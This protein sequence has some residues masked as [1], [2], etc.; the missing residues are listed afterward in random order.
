MTK[1][2]WFLLLA[3]IPLITLTLVG[4]VLF[5]QIKKFVH[6]DIRWQ[7]YPT[8]QVTL[9]RI[10]MGQSKQSTQTIL[11][12]VG[13]ARLSF[14][15]FLLQDVDVYL[16]HP[17]AYAGQ[18][19]PSLPKPLH[20]QSVHIQNLRV[21][22]RNNAVMLVAKNLEGTTSTLF[23]DQLEIPNIDFDLLK[24]WLSAY[25]HI[26]IKQQI[27]VD[28]LRFTDFTFYDFSAKLAQHE[29]M[30]QM[31]EVK[32]QLFSGDLTGHSLLNLNPKIPTYQFDAKLKHANLAAVLSHS[33]K[34]NQI[35][36]LIDLDLH[37]TTAGH[38]SKE[39]QQNAHGETQIEITQCVYQGNEAWKALAHSLGSANDLS[40]TLDL[41]LDTPSLS[42]AKITPNTPSNH[43]TGALVIQ[44]GQ[45]AGVD[46]V[47]N[48]SFP[49]KRHGYI[50]LPHELI[51]LCFVL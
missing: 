15:G 42:V 7:F 12:T 9:N 51:D 29:G 21:Q 2:G 17:E 30:V 11:A 25:P 18:T 31:S 44:Q 1:K 8:L 36:G 4:F 34:D 28:Q 43:I 26:V 49:I 19:F 47:L 20:L 40:D 14:D 33:A 23:A 6:G 37:I 16:G 10:E 22:G 45:V 24:E 50:D 32:A 48:D 46:L 39:M 41:M 3:L 13:Q 35:T 5:Y 27:H 38:N